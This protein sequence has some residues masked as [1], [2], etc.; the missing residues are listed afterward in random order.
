MN[1]NSP[2]KNKKFI[3]N[4]KIILEKQRKMWQNTREIKNASFYALLQF[5]FL[6]T[7]ISKKK[8]AN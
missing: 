8:L 2:K 1:D 5:Y 4:Q 7:A 6:K 3:E